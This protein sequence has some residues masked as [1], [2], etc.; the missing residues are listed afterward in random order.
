MKR[1]SWQ[2]QIYPNTAKLLSKYQQKIN[3]INLG[4]EKDLDKFQYNL[5]IF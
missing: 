4:K 3:V 5:Y 1:T 2:N